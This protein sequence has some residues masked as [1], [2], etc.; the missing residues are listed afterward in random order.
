MSYFMQKETDDNGK[1]S[2]NGGRMRCTNSEL[3]MSRL[4]ENIKSLKLLVTKIDG[5]RDN[6]KGLADTM[7]KDSTVLRGRRDDP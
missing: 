5:E 2:N 3:E 1:T 4:G 7:M 6:I